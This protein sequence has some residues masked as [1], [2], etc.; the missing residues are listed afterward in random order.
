MKKEHIANVELDAR[1]PRF[2]QKYVALKGLDDV[3]LRIK[4]TR[5]EIFNLV[6]YVVAIILSVPLSIFAGSANWLAV[7]AILAFLIAFLFYNLLRM[8]N[9]IDAQIKSQKQ[10]REQIKELGIHHPAL[11]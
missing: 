10:L 7:S 5:N 3:T 8:K 6:L 11:E 9:E 4:D 1:D 2:I